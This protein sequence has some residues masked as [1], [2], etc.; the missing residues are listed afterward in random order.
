VF[1]CAKGATKLDRCR[2]LVSFEKRLEQSS[3]ELGIEDGDADAIC[4][5]AIKDL[6]YGVGLNHVPSGRFGAKAAW[7]TVN[8]IAHNLSPFDSFVRNE[9][10][11]AT[12]LI[13][14]ALLAWSQMVCFEAALARAEPKTMRYLL[15]HKSRGL[16]SI[17]TRAGLDS[18]KYIF[19]RAGRGQNENGWPAIAHHPDCIGAAGP[20]KVE[21]KKGNIDVHM[22][23]DELFS[24]DSRGNDRDVRRFVENQRE[25]LTKDRMVFDHCNSDHGG[26]HRVTPVLRLDADQISDMPA[27]S[28]IR[29]TTE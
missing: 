13:A 1:D 20:G 17:S 22:F 12:S 21:V 11:V 19:G 3:M 23:G 25:A 28:S 14:G 8:V 9:A 27:T 16:T 4:E 10:W 18:T 29:A 5:N 6:K 15:V 26:T 7:L 2:G 24:A